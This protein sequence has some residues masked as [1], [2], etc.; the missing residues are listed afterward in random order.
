M[1]V[2]LH[3]AVSLDGAT[4]G[5]A[6]DQG[7]FYSLAATF[8]E[9]CTLAGSD[10]ILAQEPALANAAGPG[11]ARDGPL[12]AVVDGRSRV[13]RWTALRDAGHWSAV[14]G[15]HGGSSPPRTDGHDEIVTGRGERVDL[16]AALAELGSRFG[17]ER[18]RVDSGGALAGA[19]LAEGLLDEVSLLVHPLFAGPAGDRFW[20]GPTPPPAAS[21]ALISSETMSGGLVWSRYRVASE[22]D[23]ADPR[24]PATGG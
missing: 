16:R 5:F 7:V 9:D 3:V 15:L 4:T 13:S 17:V 24:E 18:V 21:L 14:V 1:E 19:L 8:G 23:R 6:P 20:A 22:R 10:T 12:L 2:V 11:P